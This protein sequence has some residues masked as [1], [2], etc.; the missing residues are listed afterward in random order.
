MY[1]YLKTS[2]Y[3]S[4]SSNGTTACLKRRLSSL[5]KMVERYPDNLPMQD[6]PIDNMTDALI[7][8]EKLTMDFRMHIKDNDYRLSEK[9]LEYRQRRRD[10]AIFEGSQVTADIIDGVLTLTAP[11]LLNRRSPKTYSP[12]LEEAIYV[13]LRELERKIAPNKIPCPEGKFTFVYIREYKPHKNSWVPKIPD[14]DNI[15]AGAI[16]NAICYSLCISDR[17]EYASFYYTAQEGTT[18]KTIIKVIDGS[19]KFV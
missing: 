13:A 8:S 15:E 4:T 7:E 18:D 14:N 16:T 12:Y 6:I 5:S 10:K 19:P 11:P 17:A 9:D 3:D 1:T 2:Y